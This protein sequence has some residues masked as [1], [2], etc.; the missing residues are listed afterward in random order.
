MLSSNRL[1]TAAPLF[2]SGIHLHYDRTPEQIHFTF[3]C[4]R[5]VMERRYLYTV[6]GQSPGDSQTPG[7][8]LAPG[9]RWGQTPINQLTPWDT[10]E[11][12][13]KQHRDGEPTGNE[14]HTRTAAP[15]P[16]PKPQ[17]RV[18]PEESEMSPTHHAV[19]YDT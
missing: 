8:L 16:T 12:P 18:K 9:V 15:H 2:G 19:T 7:L 14:S 17:L 5:A 11:P 4:Q 3:S 1:D 10:D 6:S 13:A